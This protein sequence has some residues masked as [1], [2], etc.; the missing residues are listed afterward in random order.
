MNPS[1]S[2]AG[3]YIYNYPM[4]LSQ[5]LTQHLINPQFALRSLTILEDRKNARETYNS[6]QSIERDSSGEEDVDS[7][8]FDD[9]YQAGGDEAI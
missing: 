9:F 2:F 5:L 1:I 6:Q 4:F 7:P 8:V 3:I